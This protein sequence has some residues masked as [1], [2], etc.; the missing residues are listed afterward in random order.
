MIDL[1]V[2]TQM[3]RP[4]SFISETL[5]GTGSPEERILAPRQY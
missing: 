3:K 2:Y 4:Q 1:L 5:P